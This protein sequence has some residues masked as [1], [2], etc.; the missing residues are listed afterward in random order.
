VVFNK[1]ELAIAAIALGAVVLFALDYFA[2][3]PFL[4][5]R[6]DVRARLELVTQ[7]HKQAQQLFADARAAEKLWQGF[8]AR[9]LKTTASE[10]ESQTLNAVRD[11]AQESGMGLSSV[12]PEHLAQDDK[13]QLQQIGFHA[14]GAGPMAALARML[15]RLESA[16]IP[17]RVNSVQV[18]SRKDATDDL[19]VQLSIATACYNPE[20][21]KPRKPVPTRKAEATP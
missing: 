16:P 19:A 9:G 11:W 20:A 6:A 21:G 5:Y 12:K 8:L 15:W 10:A 3:S 1:R 7:Q 14:M 18:A 13:D 2:V 17:L 4:D